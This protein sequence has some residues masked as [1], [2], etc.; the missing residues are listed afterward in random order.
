MFGKPQRRRDE[1]FSEEIQSHIQIEADRLIAEEGMSS[2]A[3]LAAAR[4]AF[5]N[6]TSHRE[7]FYES[8]RWMWLDSF[9]RGGRQ[10]VRQ[11]RTSPATTA[12][13][14]LS[15]ALGIGATTAIFS[16][17]D[18]AIWQELPIAEPGRLV[19]LDWNGLYIGPGRGWG[20]LMS[21]E[22]YRELRE[23]DGV[24]EDVFARAPVG[25]VL[26]S[27]SG[28]AEPVIVEIVTGAYFSTLGV[29]PAVGRLLDDS[30]DVNR[31]GHPFAVLSNAY[32][33][34]RF[35]GDPRVVG[36][37]IKINTYPFTVIGVG[38]KGFQGLDWSG[39]PAVWVPA[40]M[41]AQADVNNRDFFNARERWLHIFGRLADGVSREQAQTRLE[42]WFQAYLEAD[43][44][45]EGWP[46]VTPQQMRDFKAS[47]LDVLPAGRGVS[48]LRARIEQPMLILLAA[49]GLILLLACLNVAN[50]SLA[51]ALAR[52]RATALRAVLGAS[53]RR[54]IS[55][56]LIESGLLALLGCAAGL[57]LAPALMR[58]VLAFLPTLGPSENALGADLHLE[59]LAFA[60]GVSALTTLLSGVAPAI[61]AA[62]VR[63]A[64][65]IKE[66]SNAVAG[67]L[68][69]RKTLV[70]AQFALALILLISAGLFAQTLGTLR[71]QGPGFPTSNLLVFS[72][73]PQG[74]GYSYDESKPLIRRILA[75]LEALP[76][77]QG[78]A[79]ARRQM[80][81]G[82]SW[83]VQLTIGLPQQV[84]TESS[85]PLNAVSPGFFQT[86]G[87]PITLGRDFDDHD[88]RDDSR[89][90]LSKAIVNQ[91]FA[92]KYLGGADPLGVRIGIGGSPDTR[93][94]IEIVGVAATFRDREL[95]D[96]EPQAFFPAWESGLDGGAFYVRT[97]G[98][99]QTAGPAIR[100]AVADIDPSLAILG[101]RTVD[102]QLD[103]LLMNE[104][105]LA[106]SAVAFALVATLLAVIGLHGVMAF[107]AERRTKEMGIRIALG[108]PRW[109][110]G[111]LIVREAV[112][113]A[114]IGVAIALPLFWA[115]ARF[116]ESQLF[117]VRSLDAITVAGAAVLL[118]V[119][120]LSAGLLPARKASSVN[121]LQAL[122]SE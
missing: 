16:L 8:S 53:R 90:G 97:L 40:A 5:G 74:A 110:A 119:V 10:A 96:P 113:L 19:Q 121:P 117:G 7:R 100:S 76:E 112:S 77:V 35:G 1:D 50:L 108:A 98:S 3:A 82:G 34:S 99:S 109:Q 116:L 86:L 41:S 78:A 70:V 9:L 94:E 17:A 102:D 92:D 15:L 79:V 6:V 52:R 54:I 75:R 46:A 106:T 66:Q 67:G 65:A 23:T 62:S 24:F 31:G 89:W 18:Q 120:G 85:I 4:R 64:A 43:P 13:I 45:R 2:A 42:P 87:A 83:N 28:G 26:S 33:Q 68:G 101:M 56:Q 63:P 37:T 104:R 103:R 111:G 57:L 38:P 44:K 59:V 51:K 39:V 20:S 11:L 21:Y 105:M 118:T 69:F 95:R 29:Q 55:E 73:E 88:S 115:L 71:T 22:L 122:R 48:L 93:P 80:L 27:E 114:T 107:S 84:V 72:V 61:Y 14:I 12:I 36:K 25:A 32:W 60:V 47:T 91:E 58:A 81:T 49:T 30:D